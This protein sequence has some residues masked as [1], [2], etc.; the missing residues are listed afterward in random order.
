MFEALLD[1][2][3]TEGDTCSLEPYHLS[4]ALALTLT[5]AARLP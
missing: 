5:L 2:A 1:S 3:A 4:L